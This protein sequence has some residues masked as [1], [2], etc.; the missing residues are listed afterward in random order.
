MGPAANDANARRQTTAAAMERM[1]ALCKGG[2]ELFVAPQHLGRRP[3][4]ELALDHFGVEL[5]FL[6]PFRLRDFGRRR[7][8]LGAD[9]LEA[10]HVELLRH[11]AERRGPG[12]TLALDAITDPLQ[13]P[14]VLAVARPA[15]VS[16]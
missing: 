11:V 2:L 1:R 13:H 9:R 10:A 7:D 14:H 12:R 8:A 16:A 6:A 15:E 5:H 3:L 4:G